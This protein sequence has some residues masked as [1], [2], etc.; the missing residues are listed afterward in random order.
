MLPTCQVVSR[1]CSPLALRSVLVALSL[2]LLL[3]AFPPLVARADGNQ[4]FYA[5]AEGDYDLRRRDLSGDPNDV[6]ICLP[7][8]ESGVVSESVSAVAVDPVGGKVY[9]AIK[10]SNNN[11][12]RIVQADLDGS[13]PTN[14]LSGKVDALAVHNGML[15][16]ALVEGDYD[17][18]RRN[19]SGDPNDMRL[20]LTAYVPGVVSEAVSAVAVD[21]VGS[22][23][24]YAVKDSSNN[25]D[26]IVQADLDGSNPV[27]LMAVK[28]DALA[29]HNGMLYYV[30]YGGDY[31]LRR[32]NLSGDPNDI[33]VYLPAYV[34]SVVS[35]SVTAV[36]VDPVGSKIYFAIKDAYNNNTD[37][38][39]QADLDGSNASSILSGRMSALA[40]PQTSGP[41][42]SVQRFV[43]E[44]A[45]GATFDMGTLDID[46]STA[47]YKL[48]IY[49]TGTEDL[50]LGGNP[51]VQISGT[52]T[53]DFT[54][55]E[56]PV[57]P[58]AAGGTTTFWVKFD[59]AAAGLR[60]ATLTIP[61]NDAD[62][63]NY[64]IALQGM[65]L[66]PVLSISKAVSD[67]T[68][69]PGQ[70]ITYTITISNTGDVV[71]RNVLVS[72]TL[73]S[74]MHFVGPVTWQ[75]GY[76]GTAA[77]TADDLP[78][79][80]S[81]MSLDSGHTT[82]VTFPVAVDEPVAGGTVLT[83]VASVSGRVVA[84]TCSQPVT[85]T[86]NEVEPVAQNDIASTDED[87][88]KTISV[89]SNDRDGNGDVLSLQAVGT[90]IYGQAA[91]QG[92][93]VVYTPTNRAADYIAVF[94]YTV[95]DGSLSDTGTVTVTVT[96]DNDAPTAQNDTAATDE[97]TPVTISVLGN[98]SDSDA[99]TTLTLSAVGTP[100]YGQ[101]AI[102]GTQI[103]YTPTNRTTGY[104]SV[105]SY[106]VTDGLLSDV[107]T[108]TVTVAADND[109]PTAV[110]DTASTTEDAPVTGIASVGDLDTNDSH[111]FALSVVPTRGNAHVG[112]DGSWVY[113]PTN[114]T[115]NYTDAF[116]FVVTDTGG[117]ADTGVIT[118]TVLA[119][120][121]APQAQDDSA[122]TD[123]D[124]PVMVAVLSNDSDSDVGTI[125]S[126]SAVGSPTY[127]QAAIQG[128]QVVYTPTNRAASYTAVFTYTVTD[129]TLNDTATVTVAVTA[130]NDAPTP[131]NDGLLETHENSPLTISVLANDSDPDAGTTLS[132]SSV[133]TPS[134]GQAAIQ[135]TQIVYTPTNRTANYLATFVYTVTDSLLSSNGEVS[136]IVYVNDNT[137]IAEDGTASTTEDTPVTGAASF[138]PVDTDDAHSFELAVSPAL[139]SAHVDAGGSWIYTPTNRIA[140]Y[141][142]TFTFRVRD[143]SYHSDTGVITVSVTADNDAPIAQDD[144]V[145]TD[146]DTP[147]TVAVLSNDSDSDVGTI[148]SL[149]AV[150]SPTYGQ[151]AIQGTQV[152]YTP[153]NRAASY[154]AVFTYTVTD[155]TLN[156]TATVTVSVTADSDTPQA[157]DD[158]ASTD[159]DTSSTTIPVLDNDTDLDA[160]TTLSI[161]AVGVPGYGQV[162]IQGMQVI[163]TPTNRTAGY[164]SMFTYTVT[165][166]ALTDTATVTVT[167][168]A[169]NDPPTVAD[170]TASTTED[171]AV[172][173]IALVGDL[174]TN[175]S[176]TFAL[177]VVPTR[178]NAHVGV[179]GSWTY[180][181]TNRMAS[182]TDA[183]TF[184]VTDTGGLADTGVVTVTVSADN[185]APITQDDSASTDEDT[186]V[187]ISVLGN[188][189]DPDMDSLLWISA[190]GASNHGYAVRDGNRII[191]T[192]SNR[193]ASYTAVFTYTVTDGTWSDTATVTVD[194]TADNEAPTAREYSFL[195][196]EE[197]PIIVP[198]MWNDY[199][200]D[201]GT[202]LSLS[203]V[204]TPTI[205]Q[206][207]ILGSAVLYTPTNR[208]A[209]YT[210]TFTYTITDGA[211]N[212]TTTITA[213]VTADNDP[214]AFGDPD[215]D[216]VSNVLYTWLVESNDPDVDD[217]LSI[218]ATVCPAWLTLTDHGDG[219][220]TLSGTP[221][222]ADA[223]DHAVNL[224]VEDISGQSDT[225]AFTIHVTPPASVTYVDGALGVDDM[226][227]GQGLGAAAFGTIQ[228]AVDHTAVGGT[229]Y[230][231]EGIYPE[232]V[233]VG[234][235]LTLRGGAGEDV[236][237]SRVV[238]DGGGSG[239]A[240]TIQADHVTVLGLGL[241]NAS[242]G[243]DVTDGEGV[244]IHFCNII[245]QTTWGLSNSSGRTVDASHNWWGDRS[246]P[247]GEGDG[248]GAAVSADVSYT[249]WLG[250]LVEGSVVG[251]TEWG[252]SALDARDEADLW[253]IK[254]GIGTPTISCAQYRDNPRADFF[255]DTGK[256]YDV[257]LSDAT[258]VY[259]LVLRFYFTA[260]EVAGRF[261]ER[262]Q[263]RYWDGADWVECSA[264]GVI[265]EESVVNG[266]SYVGYVEV[267]VTDST[268][269]SLADLTGTE[270][271]LATQYAVSPDELTVH[272]EAGPE[273][274]C[275]GWT[276]WYR[277]TLTNTQPFT[278]THLMVTD[279]LPAGV[280]CPLDDP[281]TDVPGHYSGLFSEAVWFV[282][283]L[284]PGET[285]Q[286]RFSTHSLSTLAP[287]SI[288]TNTL[289][290]W[291]AQFTEPGE[292]SAVLA[293]GD[294]PCTLP[295]P[296]STPTYM[297]TATRT[298]ATTPTA[299]PTGTS[300]PISP[301]D[302]P[303]M[304]PTPTTGPALLPGLY[305]PLVLRGSSGS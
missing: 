58:V 190:V 205:G 189:R 149:S 155:G 114:R 156:D 74:G 256:Y 170:G 295:T 51:K 258:D 297:P 91:I 148:L 33:C 276:L 90:P 219:T 43:G 60:T 108:I 79:L 133:S 218:T 196:D 285:V 11:T 122:S 227:H 166:G 191:Y 46:G 75:G 281:A 14:I 234:H 70:L 100:G 207:T 59:P 160:G 129:G 208:T 269:P 220:A 130:D 186:P 252:T 45:S 144:G 194:V 180:T 116:T 260:E 131:Q 159:E 222:P 197:T 63:G 216:A 132:L 277:F 275:P 57:S 240:L 162:A 199:D 286:L 89:L 99:G 118:I 26:R 238:I 198:V 143:R 40:I 296:T 8:Y 202:T 209:G 163:Y 61:N 204:G 249:P 203:I 169:N 117:L 28:A 212:A 255:T 224:Y 92:T 251:A 304:T 187:T 6:R 241:Q 172:I 298:P 215:T 200:I 157:R 294:V 5:L 279:A 213:S 126:L 72:D 34:P 188:D 181:P 141:Q 27:D 228:Y 3:G 47:A 62:E 206:A 221:G 125:L 288:I 35:E 179:G 177:S 85:V 185:D 4:L 244:A 214:P 1:P 265:L 13:N 137:P 49:N 10:D 270:F 264:Q 195:T 123:E 235:P 146:E 272:L 98:D 246:G 109:V 299:T 210:A 243:V 229:V 289:V 201:E 236:R 192:P 273:P 30:L 96:A 66:V 171:A 250:A 65:G 302:T 22:K 97:D 161:S 64:T 287:G 245:S 305:L 271:A 152:V 168:G 248:L 184:V 217:T 104:T 293:M 231:A 253:V 121:D 268:I 115:A 48:T 135:G 176:H 164:T 165:D 263:I 81:G 119:D 20:Y 242:I 69:D 107:A 167:V 110:G 138:D 2:L 42:I 274:F 21:P 56:Q 233:L 226:D 23:I 93:Q 153:T 9:F 237:D 55:T 158:T 82:V 41:E 142:D 86:V 150:G 300:T 94:T 239:S 44:V 113:T 67:A 12:D 78:T 53:G 183:F 292:L 80:L 257:Q 247:S 280:C 54:I 52:H 223:G 31:D 32:R 145:S 140:S 124:T 77:Q 134:R 88:H 37:R 71:A 16:Y 230:I 15:Y 225:L 283:A 39:M 38:I 290:Y 127:G 128:T 262:A 95:S 111:T 73:P 29:A 154:T 174:D 232:H 211:L 278:L 303:T 18:R 261:P 36:A 76:M 68:P 291:A 19:L 151:A 182:Y 87:T 120:N 83:N 84:E 267:L 50:V 101:A 259:A 24:Y 173:G 103:V 175:D 193:A 106:T 301:T 139:G 266:V 282:D 112:L 102:Q 25:T 254:D 147:V 284:G 105:F 136:V 7:A 17:L 178:G